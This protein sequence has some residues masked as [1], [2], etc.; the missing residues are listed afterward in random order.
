MWLFRCMLVSVSFPS[1]I[2]IIDYQ[3]KILTHRLKL[4]VVMYFF[5]VLYYNKHSKLLR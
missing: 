3:Y 4:K 1:A 5:I 2:G